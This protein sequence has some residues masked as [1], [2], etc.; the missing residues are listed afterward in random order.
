METKSPTTI[1]SKMKIN[2]IE[3]FESSNPEITRQISFEI[4]KIF[5]TSEIKFPISVCVAR[6]LLGHQLLAFSENASYENILCYT[7]SNDQ[8]DFIVSKIKSNK[9]KLATPPKPFTG[10]PN[11]LNR[12]VCYV[13]MTANQESE[14]P[15]LSGYSIE[16]ILSMNTITSMIVI[17]SYKSYGISEFSNMTELSK[18]LGITKNTIQLIQSTYDYK[19]ISLPDNSVLNIYINKKQ[20]ESMKTRY[21]GL[22]RRNLGEGMPPGNIQNVKNFHPYP[23]LESVRTRIAPKL[24]SPEAAPVAAATATAQIPITMEEKEQIYEG[25][26]TF[27]ELLKADSA[28]YRYKEM[29]YPILNI[30]TNLPK[31]LDRSKANDFV[32]FQPTVGSKLAFTWVENQKDESKWME[33]LRHYVT[34]ILTPINAEE[35]DLKTIINDYTSENAMK[36][37]KKTFTAYSYDPNENYESVEYH[38]DR[39]LAMIH[40]SYIASKFPKYNKPSMLSNF[41]H[42]YMSGPAHEKYC[43]QLQLDKFVRVGSYDRVNDVIRKNLFEALFGALRMIGNTIQFPTRGD[44]IS[45]AVFGY[46]FKDYEPEEIFGFGAVGNQANELFT[47]LNMGKLDLV[48][49]RNRNAKNEDENYMTTIRMSDKAKETFIK[50]GINIS[51]TSNIVGYGYGSSKRQ[52]EGNA[53]YNMMTSL[54][55]I[56]AD[57]NW[58][59]KTKS[60]MEMESEVMREYKPYFD[61]YAKRNFIDYLYVDIPQKYMIK[62]KD[63]S[64]KM[65]RGILTGYKNNGVLMRDITETGRSYDDVKSKIGERVKNMLK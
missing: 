55:K 52:S 59:M 51:K 38:G 56:G 5:K 23:N 22:L 7:D 29:K 61:E 17:K 19:I 25:I 43:I 32:K 8:K 60:A 14:I 47:R 34:W 20:F 65:L 58:L 6:G 45:K 44:Y 24:F 41:E 27:D 36:M 50:Y 31:S 15:L 3:Y 39:S 48:T 54:W 42:T 10:V 64:I 12:W 33:S 40:G 30:N 1:A 49:D 11:E 26:T 16:E 9:I 28:A 4:D 53:Y 63:G 35:K 37:W 21:N 57:R 2:Q 62:N 18:K 13:D 46:M